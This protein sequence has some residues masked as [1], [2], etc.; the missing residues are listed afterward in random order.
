MKYGK[1]LSILGDAMCHNALQ[2]L[3]ME[4]RS[5]SQHKQKIVIKINMEGVTL[6]D[7][8]TN[9]CINRLLLLLWLTIIEHA[10]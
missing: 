7:A 10:E 2:L 4:I 8:V 3:K 6:L 1:S 5:N 9:V